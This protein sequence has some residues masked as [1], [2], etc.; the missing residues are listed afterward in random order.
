MKL[1][2]IQSSVRKEGSIS[3]L[4]SADFLSTLEARATAPVVQRDVGL[5]PPVHPTEL[6]TKASY[7]PPEERTDDSTD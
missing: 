6:W 4:L 3:R 2:S 1:L 7:M 5:N